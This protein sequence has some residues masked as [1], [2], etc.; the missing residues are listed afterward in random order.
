M[1]QSP[2]SIMGL[3]I[4]IIGIITFTVSIIAILNINA[5]VMAHMISVPTTLL[6]LLIWLKYVR[7]N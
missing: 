2:K 7:R 3:L 6:G 5:L 1:K 4:A